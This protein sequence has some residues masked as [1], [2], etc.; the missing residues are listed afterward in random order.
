MEVLAAGRLP[1]R[2]AGSETLWI[3]ILLFHHLTEKDQLLHS[4]GWYSPGLAIR[5]GGYRPRGRASFSLVRL[6]RGWKSELGEKSAAATLAF[7]LGGRFLAEYSRLDIALLPGK[8]QDRRRRVLDGVLEA[9]GIQAVRLTRRLRDL[10]D[11][12]AN[13]CIRLHHWWFY[14]PSAVSRRPL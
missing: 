7:Y 1:S 11:R 5:C 6:G 4:Y 3:Q 8:P 12:W 13:T 2:T 9:T 14:R 10:H